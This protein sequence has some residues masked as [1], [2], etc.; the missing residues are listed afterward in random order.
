MPKLTASITS[1]QLTSSPVELGNYKNFI[2]SSD[3]SLQGSAFTINALDKDGESLGTTVSSTGAA[4]TLAI[5]ASQAVV[6]TG[7]TKDWFEALEYMSFSTTTTQTAT[8]V[9]SIYAS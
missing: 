1:T 3:A 2:I 7:N 9:I 6:P 4:V 5:A 8:T